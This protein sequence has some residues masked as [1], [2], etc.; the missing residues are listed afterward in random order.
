MN[1]HISIYWCTP[2]I[3]SL[4]R[5]RSLMYHNRTPHPILACLS[6]YTQRH[7]SITHN[8][9]AAASYHTNRH[10]TSHFPSLVLLFCCT[11]FFFFS[12]TRA[13]T[14]P[15]GLICCHVP[16]IINIIVVYVSFRFFFSR[17]WCPFFRV[18]GYRFPSCNL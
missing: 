1:N 9:P 15:R 8:L 5:T 17:S 18:L 3:S 6:C 12:G 10:T 7:R 4:G 11:T 13:C 16:I 2:R 14:T